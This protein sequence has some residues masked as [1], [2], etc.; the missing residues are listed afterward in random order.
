MPLSAGVVLLP[1][2]ALAGQVDPKVT[3]VTDD[4]DGADYGPQFSADGQWLIFDRSPLRGG[5]SETYEVSINGG[6]PTPFIKERVPVAQTRLRWS[7]ATNRI[8]FTGI[9]AQGAASTWLM[10]ADGTHARP[11]YPSDGV[12]TFYPSWYLGGTELMEL[13]GDKN[14]LRRV[15]LKDGKFVPLVTTPKLLTGMASVSPDGKWI[16][17]A[18]QKDEGQRYNQIHNQVWMVSEKGDAHPLEVPEMEGRAPTWSPDGTR[19]LFESN[20]GAPVTLLYAI[21]VADKDGSHLRRLTPFEW[22]SQHPVWS[23]DG[24]WIAFSARLEKASGFGP[25]VVVMAAPVAGE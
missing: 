19:L 25:G 1:S 8:A 7:A 15:N 14:Q 16:A 4:P 22:N 20:Q 13:D 18:A 10:E 21:F 17:V 12:H 11:A 2:A 24:K 5:R 6:K 3:I 23:P 9:G